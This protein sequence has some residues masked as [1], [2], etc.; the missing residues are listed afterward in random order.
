VKNRSAKGK[1]GGGT[2]LAGGGTKTVNNIGV[3]G[4]SFPKSRFSLW[5]LSA[6]KGG[7]KTLQREKYNA[8]KAKKGGDI[9]KS[10]TDK[11]I[12][13]RIRKKEAKITHNS[14]PVSPEKKKK[15]RRP[16]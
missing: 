15:T 5:G 8:T 10:F 2:A 6:A 3:K 16:V 13:R 14:S 7:R 4:K 9:I 11:K 1:E 12:L